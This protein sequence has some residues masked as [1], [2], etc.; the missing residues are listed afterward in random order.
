MPFGSCCDDLS[1]AM[2]HGAEQLVRVE[3]NGVLYMAVGVAQTTDGLG[4]FDQAMLFCPFCGV[5]LQTREG[6]K[7]APPL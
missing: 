4:W 6:I 3:S 5:A 1:R 7:A 2:N